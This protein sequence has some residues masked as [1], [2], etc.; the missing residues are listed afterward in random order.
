L[1]LLMR[2]NLHYDWHWFW[3]T[4]TGEI[5]N[6]GIYPLSAVRR[7]LGQKTLPKWVM[8]LGG[9]FLFDDDGQTPNTQIALYQFDPGPLL[10][11]ELRNLPSTTG[12]KLSP[13]KAKFEKGEEPIG[14]GG[15]GGNY[16]AHL[17]NFFEVMRSR[18]T[19]EL[20]APL[21][22]AHISTALVHLANISYRLGA[23]R[24]VDAA[25]EAVQDRGPEA[26][27]VFDGFREHLVA[28]GVDFRT[29]DVIIGPWLEVDPGNECFVG[30]SPL[31]TKANALARGQYRKPFVVPEVV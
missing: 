11:F 20:R 18:K 5:G 1:E 7:N 21:L 17:A 24:K 3:S 19:S 23:P 27:E 25:R 12:P 15:P 16:T 28:N 30:N 9:R 8:S 22:E 2:K 4:G 14:S 29:T 10:I 13:T 26:V 6:N 31:V